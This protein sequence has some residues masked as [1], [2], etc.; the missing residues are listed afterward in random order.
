MRSDSDCM[1]LSGVRLSS[2]LRSIEISRDLDALSD[3][4]GGGIS[5]R[6]CCRM[7]EYR[8]SAHAGVRT[9]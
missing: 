8:Q 5:S 9:R 3:T 4:A 6:E 1:N 7:S 2:Q